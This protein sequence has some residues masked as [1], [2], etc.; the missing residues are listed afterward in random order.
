RMD[1]TVSEILTPMRERTSFPMITTSSDSVS[2][3]ENGTLKT[4]TDPNR[5][6][7]VTYPTIL[8]FTE[9]FLH[10]LLIGDLDI[11]KLLLSILLSHL[12]EIF[13][14]RFSPSAKNP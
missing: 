14:L 9:L 11:T 6:S 4:A 8:T 7:V 2:T 12:Y 10:S 3:K 1:R 5:M 13:P